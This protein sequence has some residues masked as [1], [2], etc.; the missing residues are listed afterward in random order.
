MLGSSREKFQTFNEKDQQQSTIIYTWVR[1]GGR[2]ATTGGLRGE[3]P[4]LQP[5][6]TAHD[7]PRGCR[8]P[9]D[10]SARGRGGGLLRSGRQLKAKGDRRQE[11]RTRK[12][13]ASACGT[14]ERPRGAGGRSA[15][16]RT[17]HRHLVD[18]RGVVLL[19]VA[20]DAD[21][22]VLDE[23]DGHALPAVPPRPADPSGVKRGCG[24]HRE[25]RGTP[26]PRGP[27]RRRVPLPVYV[28]LSV[29]GQVVIDD[30]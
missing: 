23:V 29:V 4:R 5:G 8:T 9:A 27:G 30:E 25:G 24:Q 18:L 21:V 20:Q 10:V 2:T 11:Q 7:G 3:S 6:G 28:Q 1:K 15:R 13:N 22:V 26:A 16:P 19:D 17:V 12:A 14:A